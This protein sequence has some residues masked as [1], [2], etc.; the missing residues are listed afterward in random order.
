MSVPDQPEPRR[1]FSA[2][3]L[4]A[5]PLP[6]G[7]VGALGLQGYQLLVEVAGVGLEGTL[8][9]QADKNV[10]IKIQTDDTD[11]SHA[12]VDCQAPPVGAGLQH[13]AI[14][15]YPRME[16]I[17]ARIPAL[18]LLGPDTAGAHAG[19]RF[20][21]TACWIDGVLALCSRP[22]CAIGM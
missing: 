21:P 1:G 19:R 4:A 18:H 10:V 12:F 2:G 6:P 11:R 8:E 14:C 17:V 20:A 16:E 3:H 15:G 9:P 5:H 7:I 22:R 13:R